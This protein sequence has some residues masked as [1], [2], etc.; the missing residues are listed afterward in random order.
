MNLIEKMEKIMEL[1]K[2]ILK[3]E[4]GLF[5]GYAEALQIVFNCNKE[6]KK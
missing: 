6:E 3:G 5:D 2:R 4:V 1:R